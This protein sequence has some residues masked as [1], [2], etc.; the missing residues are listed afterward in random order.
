MNVIRAKSLIVQDCCTEK[1]EQKKL[2][3]QAG[4]RL[5][6]LKIPRA[7]GGLYAVFERGTVM[8]VCAGFPNAAG[9]RCESEPV[10]VLP[11]DDYPHIAH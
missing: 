8:L 6:A 5:Y 4:S 2:D 1:I 7:S 9:V 10:N 11:Y 3:F